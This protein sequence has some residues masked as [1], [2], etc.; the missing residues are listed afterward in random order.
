MQLVNATYLWALLA[1]A[2]PVAIHLLS[3][4]EGQVIPVGSLRHLKETASQQFRGIKL[5]ELLL[6]ALRLLLFILFV[7]LLAGLFWNKKEKE[8][9]VVVD[10]WLENDKHT[11]ALADSL[12]A[13][14][15]AWHWLSANFPSKEQTP[16]PVNN[17]W[18]L[19]NSLGELHLEHAVVLS[20][21][22]MADFRGKAT[23]LPPHIDW[24]TIELAD[25]TFTAYQILRKNKVWV[26]NVVS[27]SEQTSF[28]TDTLTSRI[29]GLYLP[30]S[31]QVAIV[32]DKNFEEEARLI[33]A[34]LL[35]MQTLPAQIV[36][37]GQPKADWIIWLSKEEVPHTEAKILVATTSTSGKL[38]DQVAPAQ[39]R[40]NN[41]SVENML[42]ENATIKIAE[43]I[44]RNTALEKSVD[45]ADRRM[46]PQPKIKAVAQA[47][48]GMPAKNTFQ[49]ELLIL[50]LLVWIAERTLAF[51]R[52]Q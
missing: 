5:N 52:K 9:W 16:L 26:R 8:K 38:I 13:R 33:K 29:D 41:L 6:L 49:I 12:M 20:A 4:K 15:Y 51:V 43:L 46:M 44:T 1:L 45:T 48:M 40:L 24:Q 3:R 27:A 47:G 18:Q 22:R 25:T 30:D 21:N 50:F 17:Y 7:M 39:W 2:V 36:I 10:S 11:I 37:T 31:I 42:Q 14:G 28:N 32:A 34:S 23:S 19:M 35:A